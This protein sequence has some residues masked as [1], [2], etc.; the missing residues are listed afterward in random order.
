MVASNRTAASDV[1]PMSA[2]VNPI[3]T[4]GPPVN[5]TGLRP[6]LTIA[7]PPLTTTGQRWLTGSQ[8]AGHRPGQVG[9]WSG[10]GSG[11]HVA[12]SE[13]ATSACW[14]HVSPHGSATSAV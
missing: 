1:A 4:A 6:S 14:S 5:G 3:N 10:S 8:M 11:R 9:S 7:V 12:H 13:S 2:P